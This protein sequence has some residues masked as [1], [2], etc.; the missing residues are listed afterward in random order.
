MYCTQSENVRREFVQTNG[1]DFSDVLDFQTIRSAI[2]SDPT[3][4]YQLFVV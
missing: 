2:P 4:R 1:S 3:V